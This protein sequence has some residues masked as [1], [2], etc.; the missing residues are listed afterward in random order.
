MFFSEQSY[1]ALGIL[2]Y[3]G[4]KDLF[5]VTDMWNYICTC[6]TGIKSNGRADRQ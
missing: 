6:E 1:P 4:S 3:T 2:D 5:R